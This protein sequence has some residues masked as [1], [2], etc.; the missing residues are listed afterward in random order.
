LQAETVITL[1]CAGNRRKTYDEFGQTQGLKWDVGAI[2][3]AKWGG[4]WL[5]DV[6]RAVGYDK[7]TAEH[8]QFTG[9]D[10][11]F[12]AS[13]PFHKAVSEY[14]CVF[15]CSPAS[16]STLIDPARLPCC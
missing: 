9:D 2:S 1:Q 7:D 10:E 11:P 14:R 8:V 4:V 3:T 12:D 6:L 13:I 16:P 15:E 5:S